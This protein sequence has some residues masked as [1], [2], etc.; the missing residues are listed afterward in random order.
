MLVYTKKSSNFAP[1]SPEQSNIACNRISYSYTFFVDNL[2]Y[3]YYPIIAQD[4]SKF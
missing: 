1:D 2:Q 3:K 4:L